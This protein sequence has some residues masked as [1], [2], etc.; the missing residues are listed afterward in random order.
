MA[1]TREK[2]V[3]SHECEA[4]QDKQKLQM[5]TFSELAEC[6]ARF[7]PKV[8]F[9]GLLLKYN[10]MGCLQPLM[11]VTVFLFAIK[12]DACIGGKTL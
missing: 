12:K 7:P 4:L 5:K 6:L 3:P 2:L 9:C 11:F 8:T 10:Y 1:D